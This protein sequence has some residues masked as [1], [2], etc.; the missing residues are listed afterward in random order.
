MFLYVETSNDLNM[1]STTEIHTTPKTYSG[2]NVTKGQIFFLYRINVRDY[3]YLT[4]LKSNDI[5]TYYI[6]QTNVNCLKHVMLC[7]GICNF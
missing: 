7:I 6:Y 5:Y 3:M 1:Y 4:T 2:E